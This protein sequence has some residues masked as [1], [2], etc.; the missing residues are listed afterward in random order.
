MCSISGSFSKQKLID[1]CEANKYRG[2]LSHSISYYDCQT[3]LLTKPY[4]AFGPIDYNML[5]EIENNYCIV[6]QQAPTVEGHSEEHIHPAKYQGSCLWHNGILKQSTIE[7]LQCENNDY[8]GWDTKQLL[9]YLNKHAAPIDI[10]GSFACL[11]YINSSLY[12]FRNEIAPMFIDEEYNLSS[13]KFEGAIPIIPNQMF[14]LA[15]GKTVCDLNLE[16]ETVTNP[17]KM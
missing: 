5:E 1:L 2:Q 11:M 16:F 7:K 17:Y 9:I 4:K 10:D 6:H 13:T 12:I 14:L 3:H 8:S 15:P